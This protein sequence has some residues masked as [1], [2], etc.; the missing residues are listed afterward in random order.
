[1]LWPIIIEGPIYHLLIFTSNQNYNGRYPIQSMKI[2]TGNERWLS[3]YF[4]RLENIRLEISTNYS[5]MDIHC[6]DLLMLSLGAS[7]AKS[8]L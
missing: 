7:H 6:I 1:M 3:H 8:S 5:V 2:T 4:E